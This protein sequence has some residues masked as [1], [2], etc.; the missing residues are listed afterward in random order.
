MQVGKPQRGSDMSPQSQFMKEMGLGSRPTHCKCSTLFP[1]Q[2]PAFQMKKGQGTVKGWRKESVIN[3]VKL[4]SS[5]IIYLF[6]FFKMRSLSEIIYICIGLIG[7]FSFTVLL[8]MFGNMQIKIQLLR[9]K[10]MIAFI[11][12]LSFGN[13]NSPLIW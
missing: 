5:C 3:K 8:K 7:N 6:Y 11:L 4:V 12:C 1:Y 9:K 2:L 13:R 10:K